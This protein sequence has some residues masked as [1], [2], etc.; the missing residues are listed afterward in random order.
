[1]FTNTGKVGIGNTTP[2]SPLHIGA[3]LV[4]SGDAAAITL[5]QTG[6]NET[7]GIYLERSG[8]RKGYAIYVGGGLDSLVFQRNN[9]GTK[10][11]V[12]TLT[13]DGLVGIGNQSPTTKLVVNNAIVGAIL[14]YINGTGLSYNSEGISVAGSNTANANIGNGLTLYNNVAS[15]G[16][17]SPV[18][19]FS[20]MTAGGAYN[21]TY[22]FITGIYQGTGGDSNWAIGDLM[23]GTGAGYGAQER[24]RITSGGK[25]GMG[26]SN[27]NN[28]VDIYGN[29]SNTVGLLGVRSSGGGT[30]ITGRILSAET[31]NQTLTIATCSTEGTNERIFLKIQVVNV[32]A[33]SDMG[34]CHVGY[35]LWSKN[36]TKSATTM[37]LDS[38]NS[39]VSNTN[40]GSLS[41]SGN[42]LQYTTNRNGNYE[43]NHITIW[44]CARDSGVVS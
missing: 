12:M 31:A 6:T 24:M 38:G 4:S 16:A 9:T 14:P 2:L 29:G 36:G 5:K 11:D 41:W 10:S 18:I 19:A 22:A 43:M 30:F 37:T 7:T 40:V 3:A 27:P 26:N 44:A 13:R 17:Y 21:A 23:F 8:E 20:S 1:V 39:N 33:V 28:I 42:N 15:V 35:A 25:V 34:N 32:S